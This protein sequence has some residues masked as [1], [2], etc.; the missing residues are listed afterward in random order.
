MLCACPHTSTRSIWFPPTLARTRASA[1]WL[2]ISWNS[3]QAFHASRASPENYS[4]FK[5]QVGKVFGC[6]RCQLS[7]YV[8]F[9]FTKFDS[10]I[11]CEA[12]VAA[13][14]QFHCYHFQPDPPRKNYICPRRRHRRCRQSYARQMHL[15]QHQ[16]P[17]E[18]LDYDLKW[19]PSNLLLLATE[20]RTKKFIKLTLSVVVSHLPSSLCKI[21]RK[22]W[23]R[24]DDGACLSTSRT[25]LMR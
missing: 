16:I 3:C 12:A 20:N 11:H 6:F 5:L 18:S 4:N 15:T 17:V 1:V 14:N 19:I 7:K 2:H 22:H 23:S 9:M 10:S 25:E 8:I 13:V 21:S 24:D